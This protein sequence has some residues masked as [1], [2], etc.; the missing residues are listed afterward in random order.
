MIVVDNTVMIDFW[1]GEEPFLSEARNLFQVDGDWVVPGLWVYEFG[2]VMCKL[3]RL[4]KVPEPLKKA[5]WESSLQMVL[6]SHDIDPLAVDEIVSVT[7]LKFY[8][9]SYVFLARSKGV[10]LYTR[11]KQ[12]LRTCSDIACSLPGLG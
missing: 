8:D 5:A 2:N 3:S 4:G 12:I 9:A 7:G 11:D 10:K 6:V 1:A